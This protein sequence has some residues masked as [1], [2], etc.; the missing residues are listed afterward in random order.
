MESAL[1]LVG[2]VTVRP[3]DSQVSL[4]PQSRYPV[5]AGIEI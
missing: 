5:T 3:S 1:A 2:V 4:I